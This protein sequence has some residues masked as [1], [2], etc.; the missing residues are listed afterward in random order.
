MKEIWKPL[1]Y[2]GIDLTK[3]YEV[4]N[5]GRIRSAKSEK[6]LKTVIHK[7]QHRE[8]VVVSNGSRKSLLNIKIHRAVAQMF[9]GGYVAGYE[10]NHKDGNKLNNNASNLEWVTREKNI[11]HALENRLIKS[12]MVRCR[13]TGEIF[14]SIRRTPRPNDVFECIKGSRKTACG[15]HWEKV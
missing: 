12:T 5:C 6:I 14:K 11:E 15:Y 2:N 10:V 13:E 8:C 7:K 9:V 4:S 1:I 3:R